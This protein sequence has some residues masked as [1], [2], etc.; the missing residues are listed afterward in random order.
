MK[1][2]FSVDRVE[3]DI[4]VCIS[5]DDVQVDVPLAILGGMK[6][7]DIF[8]AKLDGEMLTDIVPMPEERDRRIQSN[9]ER[10]RR[11]MKRNKS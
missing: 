6:V 8:S 9:Q 2:I 11:L 1:K 3:G 10:L 5:D 4:A 7:R